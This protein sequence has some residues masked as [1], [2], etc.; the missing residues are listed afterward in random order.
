[1]VYPVGRMSQSNSLF[2]EGLGQSYPGTPGDPTTVV[3]APV[4]V[5]GLMLNHMNAP[6]PSTMTMPTASAERAL[7]SVK[8]YS[9]GF[10][11]YKSGSEN[12]AKSCR[13]NMNRVSPRKKNSQMKRAETSTI[14]AE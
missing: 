3:V 7:T 8:R 1:M 4:G 9:R 12:Y 13:V 11:L 5:L 6:T 2:A 14:H 10:V